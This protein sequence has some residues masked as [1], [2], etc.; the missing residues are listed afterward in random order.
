LKHWSAK[1]AIRIEKLIAQHA[2]RGEYAVFDADNTIWYQDLEETLLPYLENKG[3]LSRR[4]IDKS[5][6][7]IPFH[8]DDTLTS[9]GYKLY[10]V[11]HKIGYPWFA[12]VF[13]GFTLTEL[14]EQVDALFALNGKV[15][16]CKY[17]KNGK[18][19][20]YLPQSPRIYPGQRELINALHENGIAVYIITAAL[21]ELI[22]MIVSDP[23]YGIN[24]K[25]E[26][27]I[28][29]SCLLKDRKTQEVTTARKKIAEGHFWDEIFSKEDHYAMEVTPYVLGPDTSYVGKLAA[30]KEFIH[31]ITNPILVAGD[32]PSDHSL[33]S[34]SDFRKGGLKLW[35]N[36]KAKN[37]TITQKECRKRA[38]QEKELRLDVT[39]DRNWIMAQPKD[40]GIK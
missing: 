35:V 34:C 24:V 39:G 7:L 33:L 14:K 17:W 28:G 40:L 1:E 13:S 4:T 19:A 37:W 30:L 3:M 26:N 16:P 31:P 22:R 11:D 6:H 2:H 23:K 21:E 29:L 12:Q 32:S 5:L 8:P 18:L 38:E 15:I 20:D 36:H 25:P 9:Y 10:N 27:V